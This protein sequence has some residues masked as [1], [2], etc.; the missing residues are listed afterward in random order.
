ML[1]VEK[2]IL[3]TGVA[4][5]NTIRRLSISPAPPLFKLCQQYLTRSLVLH[6]DRKRAFFESKRIV[7]I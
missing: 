2:E 4:E 1:Q 6:Y 7:K 5:I 3:N